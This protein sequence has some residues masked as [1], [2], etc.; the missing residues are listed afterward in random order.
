MLDS[1]T[2]N[3]PAGTEAPATGIYVVSH[4]HPAHALPHDVLI[5]AHIMLPRCS[6]CADVRFSLRSLANQPI[7]ENEFFREGELLTVARASEA[8]R[9]S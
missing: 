7:G 8:S 1:K 9:S 4:L 2:S 3:L 5:P 6:F